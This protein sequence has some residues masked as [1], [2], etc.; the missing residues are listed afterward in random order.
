MDM[1]KCGCLNLSY[2]VES[3]IMLVYGGDYVLRYVALFWAVPT[4]K[5]FT[6]VRSC[7]E[8]ALFD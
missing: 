4:Q 7:G 1:V 2:H 3:A 5:T 8:K 6:I